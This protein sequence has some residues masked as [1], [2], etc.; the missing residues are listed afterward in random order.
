VAKTL[1][2]SEEEAKLIASKMNF[3]HEKGTVI[4]VL[5]HFETKE[6]LM[7]GNMD[8][9]AMILTLTT[10]RA[11]F[12][13]LSRGTLWLKGE[14]SGHFQIVEDMKVDCDQDAVI[15]A[16]RPLGPTCHT[17]NTSCFY[18]SYKDIRNG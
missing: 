11:H 18:R 4:A 10:G 9:K 14:T 8:Y 17:G 5:Q 6:I 16:V 15:L 12:Y 3:R 2:M 1:V 7:V 13:S